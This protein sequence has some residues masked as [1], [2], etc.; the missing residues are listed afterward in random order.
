[1]KMKS[2]LFLLFMIGLSLITIERLANAVPRS[3]A[4]GSTCYA[5]ESGNIVLGFLGVNKDSI[6][7]DGCQQIEAARLAVELNLPEHAKAILCN[8]EGAM[9]AFQDEVN[10]MEYSGGYKEILIEKN[11]RETYC[12]Q[13]SRKWY[14]RLL[15]QRKRSY[16]H[17]MRD[18]V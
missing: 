16:R 7:D 15:F 6:K 12:E 14:K 5:Q 10:C 13:R 2:V 8:H 3:M 1:M 17:C 18:R 11:E 9:L 4:S